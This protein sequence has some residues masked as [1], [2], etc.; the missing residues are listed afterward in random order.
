MGIFGGSIHDEHGVRLTPTVDLRQVIF[1]YSSSI[2]GR[3]HCHMPSKYVVA[4]VVAAV[5]ARQIVVL[6]WRTPVSPRAWGHGCSS[7]VLCECAIDSNHT[8]FA[9]P[10]YQVPN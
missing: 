3:I 4:P 6:S 1:W 7:V 2:Y 5:V 8:S 9:E 10:S